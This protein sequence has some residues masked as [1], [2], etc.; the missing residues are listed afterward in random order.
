M[1]LDAAF[2]VFLHQGYEHASMEDIAR[3]AGVSKPVVYDCYA[4][5]E[6]LFTELLAREEQRIL[7]QIASALPGR[8]DQDPERTLAEGLTAFL[9]A[10][11]DSPDAYRVIFLG[12]GGG[13]AAIATR[14]QRGRAAQVDAVAALTQAWLGERGAPG[15][16]TAG[17]LIAYAL[18]GAAE[19]AARAV[20]A[21][22]DCFVPE[23]IG[24]MLARMIARGQGG[25]QT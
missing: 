21:E 6:Q 22:P 4:S 11:S 16:D 5:K 18:V 3:Q 19:G 14:V 23:R 1:I 24:P 2:A 9:R 10:V 25:L 20:L 7:G 15:A 17:R 8:A 12:E 13:N